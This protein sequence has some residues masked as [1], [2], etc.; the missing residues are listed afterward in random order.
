MACHNRPRFASGIY[1]AACAV[2]LAAIAGC[3]TVDTLLPTR[4]PPAIQAGQ[5]QCWYGRVNEWASDSR[6]LRA[7]ISLCA[8]EGVSG[9][10]IELASFGAGRAVWNDPAAMARVEAA[11][12]AAVAQCRARGLWLFVSIVN[13]NMGSRKYGDPGIPLSAVMDQARQL[14]AMVK[15]HG[16]SNVAVQPVAETQTSAGK[17]F[18]AHCLKELSGFTLVYNGASRPGGVPSGYRCRAWHP[19]KTSDVVPRDALAVSDTGSIIIALSSNG[20]LD[21]P[22]DPAAIEAWTRRIRAAG[23]PVAGYY[24]FLRKAHDPDA[25]RALGRA[26][27]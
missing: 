17:Q 19:F 27:R 12:A 16:P 21:G 10:M 2:A 13:D 7:D 4:S 11:Y 25:I 3:A 8:S 1:R 24:A 9:Y 14:C 22:G 26:S 6:V 5:T 20:T 23:C 18:E 15:R